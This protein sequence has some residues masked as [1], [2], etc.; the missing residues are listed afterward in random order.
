MWAE[1]LPRSSW[2]L[3]RDR[4][5]TPQAVLPSDPRFS[6]PAALRLGHG[7]GG[8]RARDTRVSPMKSA[9]PLFLPASPRFAAPCARFVARLRPARVVCRVGAPD[10]G[11]Y[12]LTHFRGGRAMAQASK[13]IAIFCIMSSLS[14][15]ASSSRQAAAKDGHPDAGAALSRLRSC[16]A[17]AVQC[18]ARVIEAMTNRFESLARRCDH[19]AIFALVYLRTTEVYRD[20]IESIGYADPESIT[21]EDALFADYYFRAY[22]AYHGGDGNVPPA[23]QI[24]FDSAEARSLSAQ[25]NA[26]LGVS[27]HIQRDLPF[28]LL[29][30]HQQ[31]HPVSHEDH[32]LVNDFLAQVDSAPEIVERFDPTYPGNRDISLIAAWREAAFS[33]FE[34]LRDATP[35]E[36]VVIAAEIEYTAALF[37]QNV[38]ANTAYPQGQNASERDAYCRRAAR[39]PETSSSK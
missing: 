36:R 14:L 18:V 13:A 5:D 29:E 35:V 28:V 17:G 11:S 37:A 3:Q 27:A 15:S 21:R 34:R 9:R 30:L 1:N 32:T 10:R 25:G 38:V 20:T 31:G 2:P 23:W 8:R 19:D 26:L 39:S 12:P 33:N 6:C 24:A 16:Q 4:A 22:D 7:E